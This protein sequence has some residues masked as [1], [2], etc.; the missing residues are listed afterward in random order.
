MGRPRDEPN[1]LAKADEQRLDWTAN[2]AFEA[3]DGWLSTVSKTV[4]SDY[5]L[6]FA[7]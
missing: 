3:G 5:V 6:T 4:T 1:S 2:D 7:P